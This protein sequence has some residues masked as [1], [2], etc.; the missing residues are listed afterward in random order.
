MANGDKEHALDDPVWIGFLALLTAL[1]RRGL[2]GISAEVHDIVEAQH[3]LAE[4]VRLHGRRSEPGLGAKYAAAARNTGVLS[5]VAPLPP[6]DGK[7]K[8]KRPKA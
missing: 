3:G 2:T 1:E 8:R 5:L 6:K 4:V 7:L